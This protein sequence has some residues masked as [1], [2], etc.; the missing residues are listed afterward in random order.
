M[1]GTYGKKDSKN[2]KKI[3]IYT[4]LDIFNYVPLIFVAIQNYL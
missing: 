2:W 3:N 1:Y 4:L